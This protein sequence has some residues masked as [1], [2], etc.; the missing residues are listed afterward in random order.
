VALAIAATTV[1]IATSA[2]AGQTGGRKILTTITSENLSKHA[3]SFRY[4]ESGAPP[5]YVFGFFCKLAYNNLEPKRW[6]SCT[7]QP[8]TYHALESGSYTFMVQ[9]VS[10]SGARSNVATYDFTIA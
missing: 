9:G 10:G 7:L 3:A 8:K 1:S 2:A 4:I 5:R 6:S